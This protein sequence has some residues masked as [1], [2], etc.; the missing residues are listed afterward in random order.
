MES[1]DITNVLEQGRI[2][3]SQV[4]VTVLDR[5]TS[6]RIIAVIYQFGE[7]YNEAPVR[8]ALDRIGY[9]LVN[10]EI[11]DTQYGEITMKGIYDAFAVA[12][13]EK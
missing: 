12:E 2:A 11:A 7:F 8:K 5:R 10:A 13:R 1:F 3:V 4:R 6:E 9:D